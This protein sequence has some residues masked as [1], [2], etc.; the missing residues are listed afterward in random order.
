MSRERKFWPNAWHTEAMKALQQLAIQ[1]QYITAD[2]LRA[3]VSEPPDP[4]MVGPVFNDAKTIGLL[5]DTGRWVRSRREPAK[6]RKITVWESSYHRSPV[7]DPD[8]VASYMQQEEL[9]SDQQALE[10]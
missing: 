5:I 6:A 4:D 3:A 2:E 7:Q 10:V 8:P 1:K 9:R